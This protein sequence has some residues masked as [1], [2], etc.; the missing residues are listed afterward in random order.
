[1]L[2]FVVGQIQFFLHWFLATVDLKLLLAL[3]LLTAHFSCVVH[4][5]SKSSWFGFG[6][7]GSPWPVHRQYTN[8]FFASALFVVESYSVLVSALI[9]LVP[10]D[11][12]ASPL[13]FESSMR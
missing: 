12:A 3:T 6:A 2:S 10:L 4:S 1:V 5:R 13:C 7:A 9:F 11:L 8:L